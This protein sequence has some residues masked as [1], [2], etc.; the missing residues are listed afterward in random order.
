MDLSSL[1]NPHKHKPVSMGGLP[2]STIDRRF[3]VQFPLS[4]KGSVSDPKDY[5]RFCVAHFAAKD[6]DFTKLGTKYKGN[7]AFQSCSVAACLRGES[8]HS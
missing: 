6:S 7:L 2:S 8:L 1:Q 4:L 3:L 5:K